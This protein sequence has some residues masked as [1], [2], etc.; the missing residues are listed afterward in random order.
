MIAQH[1]SRVSL[2]AAFAA[3]YLVW[4]STYLAIR[5][6]IETVPPF[7]MAGVRFL[8]S[9]GILYGWLRASGVSRP[10]T[11]QWRTALVVGALILLV[12]NGGVVWAEQVVPSG[13]TA[14]LV[15]MVPLW[16]VLL[17]WVSRRERPSV[18]V[19]AGLIA[20]FGGVAFLV[21]PERIVGGGRI[22]SAGAF[23]IVLATLG[24]AIGSLYYREAPRPESQQFATALSMLAGG[25]LLLAAG[26]AVGETSQLDL[27]QISVRSWVAFWYLVFFGSLVAFSSY[28]WLMRAT[29]PARAST[30]VNPVVA[31]IL[32]WLLANELLNLRVAIAAAV[33]VSA[34]AFIV[35]EQGESRRQSTASSA[36]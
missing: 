31:V 25:S 21:G 15:A 26:V 32:G 4:G 20:G 8:I 23:A 10:T 5:F 12:G 22:H 2:V 6:A 34:V 33:F 28:L 35:T 11:I 29:T 9:G 7:S 3:V 14:L 30:Y 13:V 1:P 19:V 17:V 24:W 36:P 27:S 16:V 18:L